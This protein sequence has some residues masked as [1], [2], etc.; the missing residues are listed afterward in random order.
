MLAE[1]DEDS[2]D[3]L[4]T[5]SVVSGDPETDAALARGLFVVDV[6]Q[7]GDVSALD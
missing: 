5:L 7:G 3:L 2:D 6:D 1:S 4:H